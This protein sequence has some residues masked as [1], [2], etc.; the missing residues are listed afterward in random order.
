MTHDDLTDFYAGLAMLALV[1][2]GAPDSSLSKH[3]YKIADAMMEERKRR[4]LEDLT[5]C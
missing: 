4:D 2:K 1:Q 5:S 3:A